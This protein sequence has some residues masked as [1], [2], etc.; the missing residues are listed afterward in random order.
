MYQPRYLTGMVAGAMTKSNLI[1][2]VAAYPIPEVVRG[3]NAFTL[4][5]KS[6]NPDA[7]VH[8]MWTKTWYDPTKEKSVA[9][10]LL[11]KG[12]DV[13]TQHQDSPATQVAAQKWN[14]YSIGYNTDMSKFAPTAHL[15]ASVWNWKVI[16][17]YIV[18]QVRAGTWKSEDIWWGMEKGVVDMAPISNVVPKNIRE[19]IQAKRQELIKGQLFVFE[20]PIKDQKGMVRIPANK[21]ATDEQLLGMQWFVNGVIGKIE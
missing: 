2:Y 11:N 10:A 4:G 9:T 19:K 3:I 7:E 20:G 14:V 12:V 13:I 17:K 5:V 16:Y 21:K 8:V 18:D 6:E 15:T 1:G